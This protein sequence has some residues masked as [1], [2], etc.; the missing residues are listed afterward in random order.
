MRAKRPGLS[1]AATCPLCTDRG[2]AMLRFSQKKPDN[3][4]IPPLLQTIIY[5]LPL[6]GLLLGAL[7]GE[8]IGAG[9]GLVTAFVVL[10]ACQRWLNRLSLCTSNRLGDNPP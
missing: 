7:S 9:I 10:R 2:C 4:P 1:N 6:T 5:G 8:V 3:K